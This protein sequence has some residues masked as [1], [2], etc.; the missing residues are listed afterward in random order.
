MVN[1]CGESNKILVV[2]VLRSQNLLQAWVTRIDCDKSGK[3]KDSI[4]DYNEDERA[5]P[6]D[7]DSLSTFG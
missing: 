5:S 4:S 6:S 7:D 2:E 1:V 3:S